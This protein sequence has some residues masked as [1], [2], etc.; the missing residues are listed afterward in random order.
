MEPLP[1][2]W[3]PLSPRHL[4]K[5]FIL[6]APFHPNEQKN[7]EEN[8]RKGVANME[9]HCA[10]VGPDVCRT[11]FLR[12]SATASMQ[13]C[14]KW[15]NDYFGQYPIRRSSHP[16]LPSRPCCRPED[17]QGGG[18]ALH[19]AGAGTKLRTLDGGRIVQEIRNLSV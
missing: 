9:K 16:P 5:V 15:T 8:I 14:V 17:E 19:F 10:N 4:S 3:D 11:L 13:E 6:G 7:F 18:L 1:A 2:E 12:V